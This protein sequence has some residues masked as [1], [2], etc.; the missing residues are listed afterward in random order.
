MSCQAVID[1]L[2]RES[3]RF[4]TMIYDRIFPD[5]P[6]IGLVRKEP[7]PSAMGEIITNLT[8]ERSAPTDAV[9]TWTNVT[10]ES[11]QEGGACL[12]PVTKIGIGS[13]N[14]T[15]QLQRRAL[16]GPDICVEEI[17]SVFALR[18]QLDKIINIL[19]DYA[20]LEW[21]IR[22]RHEYLRLVGLKVVVRQAG[23]VEGTGEG[24]PASCP[25]AQLSQGVLN[26]YGVRLRRNGANRSALGKQNGAGVLTLIASQETIDGLIFQDPEI[27]QDFRWGRP[28]ELLGQ[29]GI[30][31]TY[32][33]FY[34]LIDEFPI[35]YTC[36]G[37]VYTEVAPFDVEAATKG[38]RAIVRSAWLS[39]PYEVSFIYDPTVFTS[40]I[41]NTITN[42]HPDFRFDPVKYTGEFMLRNIPDRVCNPDGTIVYHRAIL[43]SASEPVHPERGVAFVHLRCDAPMQ[44]RDVCNS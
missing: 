39:A 34:H 37:G 16:E 6:W 1:I 8:Y 25:T 5:S 14:R 35:R 10:V 18:S 36:S 7:W 31:G 15:F 41:P 2:A 19:A 29:Y 24:F 38:N 27:R 22:Y 43:M 33:G 12:P 13:T 23:L 40:L 42:P 32:R 3:G 44:L 21:E 20:K 17:R 26:R 9:P 28:S 4:S 11:G 30:E